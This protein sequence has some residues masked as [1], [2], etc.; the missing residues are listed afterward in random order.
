MVDEKAKVWYGT[1][2]EECD[3]CGVKITTGFIDGKTR[4]GPWANMCPSCFQ[5]HG[6]GLGLGKGQAYERMGDKWVK[7]AG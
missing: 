1:P 6:V 2:P 5:T 7:V 4:M 3:I